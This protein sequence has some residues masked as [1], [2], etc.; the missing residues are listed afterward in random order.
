MTRLPQPVVAWV[1]PDL[2]H[3]DVFA[4]LREATLAGL[5]VVLSVDQAKWVLD[6]VRILEG[7]AH[8]FTREE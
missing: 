1:V 8:E 5:P 7:R 2:P 3:A 6:Q 4:E